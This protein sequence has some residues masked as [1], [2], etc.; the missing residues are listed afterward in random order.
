MGNAP[1]TRAFERALS[2]RP[3]AAAEVVAVAAAAAA[4]AVVAW[5]EVRGEMRPSARRLTRGGHAAVL[6]P[7]SRSVVV[8]TMAGYNT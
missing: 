1:V 6:T 2:W 5:G 8:V 3:K 4:A 7:L